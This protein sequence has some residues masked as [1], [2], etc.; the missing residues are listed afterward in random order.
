MPITPAVKA[1][2]VLC[3]GVGLLVAA[4]APSRLE[5]GPVRAGEPM[6]VAAQAISR[7]GEP[8]PG[9]ASAIRLD[10]GSIEATCT[11]AERYWIATVS[12]VELSLQCSRARAMGILNC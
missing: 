11:N 9:L 1:F 12:G 2:S 4:T 6:A 10:D 5:L 7:A 8:C 3:L